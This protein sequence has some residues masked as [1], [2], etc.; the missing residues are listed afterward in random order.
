MSTIEIRKGL[1]DGNAVDLF[2]M[3]AWEGIREDPPRISSRLRGTGRQ[4]AKRLQ[5]G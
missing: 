5:I 1:S 2:D 3:A 4:Q